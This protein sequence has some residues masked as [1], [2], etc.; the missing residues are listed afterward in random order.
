MTILAAF[1]C[2]Q[3]ELIDVTYSKEFSDRIKDG[4]QK[5][6]LRFI[7]YA[8]VFITM[9]TGILKIGIVA[10]DW[11]FKTEDLEKCKRDYAIGIVVIYL[12]SMYPLI[13][14]FLPITHIGVPVCIYIALH[15]VFALYYFLFIWNVESSYPRMKRTVEWKEFVILT[16]FFHA[17]IIPT[18]FTFLYFGMYRNMLLMVL[19]DIFCTPT[20]FLNLVP[21]V[22]VLEETNER[23]SK[24]LPDIEMVLLGGTVRSNTDVSVENGVSRESNRPTCAICSTKY[25]KNCS[26]QTPRILDKCGHTLCE[27]CIQ[28]ILKHSNQISC[29]ICKSVTVINECTCKIGQFAKNYGVLQLVQ[30]N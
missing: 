3:F 5:D 8:L 13:L 26:T 27:G 11:K 18:F 7:P 10:Y 17:L 23:N 9:F 21:F 6:L 16:I 2:Y 29:P 24:K 1:I 20:C 30:E 4:I 15:I 28:N 12:I 19:T 22:I 25:S 14:M